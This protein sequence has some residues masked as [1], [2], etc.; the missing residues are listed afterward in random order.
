MKIMK[1]FTRM[2]ISIR[3]ALAS[4]ALWVLLVAGC[5]GGF[6]DDNEHAAEFK[7]S[8]FKPDDIDTSALRE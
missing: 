1:L 2:H 5:S 6:M 4:I 3:I 7:E 8:I